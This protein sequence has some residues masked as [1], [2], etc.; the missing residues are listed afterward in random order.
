MLWP[1][2]STR[3][4]SETS[5]YDQAKSLASVSRVE[6]LSVQLQ[7]A[8][9]SGVRPHSSWLTEL[10]VRPSSAKH[11]PFCCSTVDGSC[12]PPVHAPRAA[13]RTIQ[14]QRMAT[15]YAGPRGGASRLHPRSATWSAPG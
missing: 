15:F 7:R 13:G 11:A 12:I 3:P 9:P 2:H 8:T 5:E 14:V 4:C 1:R 10:K 6:K